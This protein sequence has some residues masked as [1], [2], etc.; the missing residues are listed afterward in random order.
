MVL[1]MLSQ[2][3]EDKHNVIFAMEEPETA[4]PP[5]TQKRI[6]QEIRNLSSQSLFTSHSPYVI[7]EFKLEEIVILSRDSIGELNQSKIE[8]P[9]SIKHKRF[10]KDFRNRFCE[11]LLSRRIIIAEGATENT[12][13]PAVARKLSELDPGYVFSIRIIRFFNHRC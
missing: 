13:L 1:A 3:A 10:R 4:I 11:G 8:L 7:E 9:D 2:I 12:S 6:I 5:Y